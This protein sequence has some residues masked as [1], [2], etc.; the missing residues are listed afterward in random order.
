MIER[1]WIVFVLSLLACGDDSS[2]AA[3]GSG[4]GTSVSTSAGGSGCTVSIHDGTDVVCPGEC[5]GKFYGGMTSIC[6]ATCTAPEDSCPEG[7]A[8]LPNVFGK[9]T[10]CLPPCESGA[11]PENL[12]C[13]TDGV[14]CEPL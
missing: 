4:G 5:P 12:R 11:C 14:R 8:C 3:S 2:S 9:Y 13:S 1:A 7:T 6:T 10:V